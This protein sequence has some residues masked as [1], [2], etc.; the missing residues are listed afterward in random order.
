[1]DHKCP[2]RCA[3]LFLG[4]NEENGL[5]CVYHGWKFDADGNCVDTP[6]LAG[7]PDFK[8]RIKARAYRVAERNGLIWVYM[9]KRTEAHPVAADRSDPA[10]GKRRDVRSCSANAT[11]CRRWK[12]ISTPRVSAFCMPASIDPE[13][14]PEDS[15]FRF[16][17]TNRAPEYHVDRYRRRHDVCPPIARPSRAGP[18]GASPISCCRSGPRRRRASSPSICTTARGCRSTTTTRCSSA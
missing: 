1:M 2:H 3:S 16:T 14:V 5:R 7:N 12:A 18:T 15:L 4:R 13:I 11:G 6:N 10:A 9:G 8:N 17:V